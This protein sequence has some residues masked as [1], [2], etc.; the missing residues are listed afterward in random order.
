MALQTI[1][2]S[3]YVGLCFIIGT[4]QQVAIRRD[5]QD[6]MESLLHKVTST[7]YSARNVKLY[8]INDR[9]GYTH[10]RIG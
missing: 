1:S 3:V 7:D 10:D 2:E 8:M 9:I 5:V 4:P 6:I